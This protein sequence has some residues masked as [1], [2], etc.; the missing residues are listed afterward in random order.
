KSFSTFQRIV[1]SAGATSP[2][3]VA[4]LVAA[5]ALRPAAGADTDFCTG[6]TLDAGAPLG[7]QGPDLV[8]TAMTC[9]VDG[10]HKTY[11]FHDVYIFGSAT[12]VFDNATMD[13]YAAN[14]V[15]QNG[16]ILQ[17]TGIG[18]DGEVLTI[19]L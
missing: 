19:H 10:S 8:V 2:V 12:L 14:I 9:T 5:I 4:V 17:A 15:V 11:N 16:G 3:L 1:K 7:T 18:K 13:F 6:G